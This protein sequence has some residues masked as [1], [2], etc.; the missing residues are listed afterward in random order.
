[1]F[2]MAE[3][4]KQVTTRPQ[5]GVVGHYMPSLKMGSWFLR[6]VPLHKP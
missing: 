1:M 4:K 5:D 3:G 6:Q 2:I